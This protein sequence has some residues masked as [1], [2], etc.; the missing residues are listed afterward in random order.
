[1]SN[2]KPNRNSDDRPPVAIGHVSL[3]VSNVDTS[4]NYFVKLGLR[5]IHE[6]ENFAVLELRGGTHLV[7][8]PAEEKCALG[9]KAPFD[10]MVDDI[11]VV[12]K[13]Y[14]DAGMEPSA[15]EEGKI[16]KWFTIIDPSGYE[17]TVTSSHAGGRAV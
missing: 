7:I 9:T 6:S 10:L 2:P 14:S 4:T 15:I 17:I 8:R 1:M 5:S 12:Q 11:E 3:Q 16:H 13:Q